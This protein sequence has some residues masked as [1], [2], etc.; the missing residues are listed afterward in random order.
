MFLSSL[1][2]SITCFSETLLNDSDVDSY[3]LPN[4]VSVNQI[5]NHYK[6]GRTL[7]YIHESFEFKIRNDRNINFK[8][9]Q[10]VGVKLLHEKRRNN[11]F[12]VFYRPPNGKI[13]PFEN[14][15][16]NISN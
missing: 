1:N 9:I 4:Y 16:K 8:N 12:N 6:E 2:F 5:K 10:S 3:E 14:L 15:L 11:L 13:E 7:V